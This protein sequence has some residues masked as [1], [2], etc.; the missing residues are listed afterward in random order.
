VQGLFYGVK[1][2]DNCGLWL[3]A[4]RNQAEYTEER[5]ELCKAYTFYGVN[6]VDNYGLWLQAGRNPAEYT[7]ERRELC[8]AYFMA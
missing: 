3:Q 6:M 7:E 8:K 4:G 1:M 5:R 2:V